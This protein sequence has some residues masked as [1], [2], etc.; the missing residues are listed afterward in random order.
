MVKNYFLELLV[1]LFLLSEDNVTLSL[2]G[3]GL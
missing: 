3:L 2:D 1:D